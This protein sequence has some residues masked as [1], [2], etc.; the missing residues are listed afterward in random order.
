LA[1]VMPNVRLV[2]VDHAADVIVRE[3]AVHDAEPFRNKR[4]VGCRLKLPTFP[5]FGALNTIYDRARVDTCI[6]PDR[7]LQRSIAGRA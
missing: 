3:I 4:G 6:G 5:P 1:E 7:F 2:G